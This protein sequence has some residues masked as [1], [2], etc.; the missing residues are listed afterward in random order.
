MNI[1]EIGSLNPLGIGDGFLTINT[2]SSESEKQVELKRNVHKLIVEGKLKVSCKNENHLFFHDE[3]IKVI[4]GF[5]NTKSSHEEKTRWV[6]SICGHRSNEE[7]E[8]AIPELIEVLKPFKHL[9]PKSSIRDEIFKNYPASEPSQI[10]KE[11]DPEHWKEITGNWMCLKPECK[12]ACG[13][14]FKDEGIIE[15]REKDPKSVRSKRPKSSP[16]SHDE[17]CNCESHSE[18]TTSGTSASSSARNGRSSKASSKNEQNQRNKEVSKTP[19]SAPNHLNVSAQAEVLI[20]PK[21]TQTQKGG[22][23]FVG[24]TI[25]GA[26][27]LMIYKLFNEN[28][29]SIKSEDLSKLL[30]LETSSQSRLLPSNNQAANNL[31]NLF[32]MKIGLSTQATAA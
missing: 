23:V 9:L 18:P 25:A 28:K 22:F 12:G 11:L 21:Y 17:N 4:L 19:V 8:K 24:A 1:N 32:Q 3:I 31:T 2:T 6:S 20:Q 26:L 15:E 14:E 10:E 30:K 27:F 16:I 13:H 29:P 7:K 5:L